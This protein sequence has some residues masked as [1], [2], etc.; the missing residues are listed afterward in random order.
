MA[1]AIAVTRAVEGGHVGLAR[2][3]VAARGDA[4]CPRVV[5]DLTAGLL[6]SGAV[7]VYLGVTASDGDKV[8]GDQ[9]QRHYEVSC[10]FHRFLLSL[11]V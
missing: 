10:C 6:G 1:E 5:T 9:Q 3:V 2:R 8:H 7:R 11:S 4:S